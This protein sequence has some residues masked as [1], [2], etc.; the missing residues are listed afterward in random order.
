M[1]ELPSQ[2]LIVHNQSELED[3]AWELESAEGQFS[4]LLARCN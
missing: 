2:A 4:L 1:S 3:L